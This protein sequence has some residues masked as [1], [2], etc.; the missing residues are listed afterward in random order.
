MLKRKIKYEDFNGNDSEDIFYFNISKPELIE[1]E[2]ENPNG[3]GETIK[4][5]IEAKDNKALIKIFKEIVLLAY[6]EKSEDGK[7][8]IKT[9][10]LRTEFS[11]TAAFSAL[12][13]EL[14]TD[15][16]SAEIFL[17]GVLPKDM[18]SELD[19]AL[20]ESKQESST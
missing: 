19:K 8:F 5:I 6:G 17:K 13:T 7:R 20:K 14:A 4:R 12:F 9:E 18:V 15:E 11:Q 3:F 10:D 2:V 1:M 16:N